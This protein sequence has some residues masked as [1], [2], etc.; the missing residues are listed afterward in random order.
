[1]KTLIIAFWVPDPASGKES[2]VFRITKETRLLLCS[3]TAIFSF[4]EKNFIE[5]DA[6][7]VSDRVE[8]IRHSVQSQFI[9]SESETALVVMNE[10]LKKT[11]LRLLGCH[12]S[13]RQE[14]FSVSGRFLGLKEEIVVILEDRSTY[15]LLPISIRILSTRQRHR[16]T[17]EA[18]GR[19][20]MN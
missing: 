6:K 20:R 1:M 14:K 19:F 5:T 9:F 11:F 10:S 8:L 12:Q 15:G 18:I 4:R 17:L 16:K 3:G 2:K 7:T 13:S